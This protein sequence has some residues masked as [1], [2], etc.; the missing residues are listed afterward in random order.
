VF[1]RFTEPARRAIVAAREEARSLG[2]SELG[3]EHLLLG[4]LHDDGIA[5][6]WSRLGVTLVQARAAVPRP[7]SDAAAAPRFAADAKQALEGAWRTALRAGATGI[8]VVHL[9]E[10]T[11]RVRRGGAVEVLSALGLSP[12]ALR[13]ALADVTEPIPPST[14]VDVATEL[15]PRALSPATQRLLE[16]SLRTAI[17][18]IGARIPGAGTPARLLQGASGAAEILRG[19]GASSVPGSI[20]RAVAGGLAPAACGFCGTESPACGALFT[21]VSGALICERCVRSRQP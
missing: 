1:E 10:G 9:A 4:V 13:A 21:G 8:G 6:A 17:A 3:S 18:M 20:G 2:A 16:H 14:I 5:G 15:R 12:D 11:L 7:G 19:T